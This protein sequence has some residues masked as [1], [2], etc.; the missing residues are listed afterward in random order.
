MFDARQDILVCLSINKSAAIIPASDQ[1]RLAW[2][3]AKV[4]LSSKVINI[5]PSPLPASFPFPSLNIASSRPPS[6]SAASPS[7]HCVQR[8]NAPPLHRLKYPSCFSFVHSTIG[9][10]DVEST[11]SI[12]ACSLLERYCDTCFPPCLLKKKNIGFCYISS[13]V[14]V[15]V[16]DKTDR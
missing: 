10:I 2:R 14:V 11:C 4:N 16:I 5:F 15:V 1:V 8:C 12:R 3:K 7:A 6:P 9:R 13:L